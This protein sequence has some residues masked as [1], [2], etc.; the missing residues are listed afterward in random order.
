MIK[1]D[2][3][4]KKAEEIINHVHQ[5]QTEELLKEFD[6]WYKEAKERHWGAILPQITIAE[7]CLKK[8]NNIAGDTAV[9]KYE[10]EKGEK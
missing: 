2:K 3:N 1:T 9:I 8:Y 4:S 7:H 10:K 5:E 6:L